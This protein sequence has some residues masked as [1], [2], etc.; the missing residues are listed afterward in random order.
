[1]IW[2]QLQIIAEVATGR[3]LNSLPEGLLIAAFAGVMLRLLPRQNSGTRFAV[4][5]PWLGC[6]SSAA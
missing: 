3:F 5:W 6:L 4:C 2:P 1:M